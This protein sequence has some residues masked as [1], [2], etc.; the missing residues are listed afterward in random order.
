M[1]HI[2]RLSFHV[3]SQIYQPNN[4]QHG[5]ST[6]PSF[7]LPGSKAV[8]RLEE[9]ACPVLRISSWKLPDT[10]NLAQVRPQNRK[11]RS[12]RYKKNCFI[13]VYL[14]NKFV[15]SLGSRERSKV[16]D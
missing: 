5:Y 14:T 13:N 6:H 8:G 10:Y 3:E 7:I 16:P 2:L 4:N 1:L 12:R 15:E 11:E 9:E